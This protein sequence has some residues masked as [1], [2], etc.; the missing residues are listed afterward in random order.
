MGAT[1]Q[2]GARSEVFFWVDGKGC[3]AQYLRS[4]GISRENESFQ[5]STFLGFAIF[6][7]IFG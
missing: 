3:L 4:V 1:D 2:G 7:P 5:E 6:D